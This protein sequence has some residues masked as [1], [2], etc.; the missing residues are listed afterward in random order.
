M[1]SILVVDDVKVWRDAVCRIL[2]TRPGLQVIAQAAD[3]EEAVQLAGKLKPDL[4]VLDIG[5]PKLD[6]LHAAAQIFDLSPASKVVFLSQD[7]DPEIVQAALSIGPS[8]YVYKPKATT[9]L[10]YAIKATFEASVHEHP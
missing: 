3:G 8:A 9:E 6:G 7:N 2:G 1:R 4:I 10:L 5:L